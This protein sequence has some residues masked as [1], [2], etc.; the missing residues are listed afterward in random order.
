MRRYRD[1]NGRARPV[2]RRP[3]VA[4]RSVSAVYVWC[5]FAGAVNSGCDGNADEVAD[6]AEL[7]MSLPE[8]ECYPGSPYH[9]PC[10]DDEYHCGDGQCVDGVKVCDRRVDCSNGADELKWYV[11]VVV[12]VDGVELARDD[13]LR[14]VCASACYALMFQREDVLHR[15][16]VYVQELH[17][18]CQLS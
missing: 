3:R 16:A 4:L 13:W 12:V 10:D 14:D 15:S 5:Y 1:L 6:I 8:G 2:W 9:R 17:S 11:L 7:C 18:V